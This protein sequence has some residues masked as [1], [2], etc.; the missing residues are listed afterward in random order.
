MNYIDEVEQQYDER[1]EDDIRSRGFSKNFEEPRRKVPQR[2]MSVPQQKGQE[3]A[4]SIIAM[5]SNLIK[6][7]LN[8][9]K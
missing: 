2:K 3:D 6:K 8:N 4:Y 7:L 9:I 1:V 5:Q